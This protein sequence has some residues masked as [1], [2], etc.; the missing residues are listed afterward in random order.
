MSCYGTTKLRLKKRPLPGEHPDPPLGV[1]GEELPLED[2]P[3]LRREA[4]GEA[5]RL[6]KAAAFQHDGET[7][8]IALVVHRHAFIRRR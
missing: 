7:V 1:L 4:A 8:A 2:G 3:Q 5:D 6:A